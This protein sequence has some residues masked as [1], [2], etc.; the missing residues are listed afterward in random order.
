MERRDAYR[1]WAVTVILTKEKL[2]LN[3]KNRDITQV[4]ALRKRNPKREQIGE[5]EYW[6][7]CFK[8][9]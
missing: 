4:M 2:L 3:G 8:V 1:G 7:K 9:K 5:Y 6:R